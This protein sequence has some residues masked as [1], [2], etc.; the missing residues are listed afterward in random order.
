MKDRGTRRRLS[1]RSPDWIDMF[2]LTDNGIHYLVGGMNCVTGDFK[3]Q[4]RY[5]AKVARI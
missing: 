4:G 3:I 1:A 2:L 5:E